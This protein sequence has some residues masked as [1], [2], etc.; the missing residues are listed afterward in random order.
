[1]DWTIT[2]PF[3]GLWLPPPDGVHEYVFGPGPAEIW[4]TR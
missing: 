4:K 3:G 1:L 2:H